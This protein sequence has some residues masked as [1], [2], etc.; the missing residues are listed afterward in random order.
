[1]E[2][3]EQQTAVAEAAAT[4][5]NLFITG[6]GGV[7]KSAMLKHLVSRTLGHKQVEVTAYTGVAALPIGGTTLHSFLGIRPGD[8]RPQDYYWQ[9]RAKKHAKRRIRGAE[10][11]VIDEVSMVDAQMLNVA[12]YV[13]KGLREDPRPFGGVQLIVLGDF[14]QLPPPENVYKLAYESVAW[15]RARIAIHELTTVFR[16]EDAELVANL[17][18]VRLGEVDADCCRYFQQFVRQPAPGDLV[19]ELYALNRDV[20]RRNAEELAKLG[21]PLRTY[22]ADDAGDPW[23]VGF[24]QK[25]CIA[26]TTLDLKTGARVM[27]LKNYPQDGLVNGSLGKVVETKGDAVRVAFKHRGQDFVKELGPDTWTYVARGVT[28]A[29]R[30]QIPL[31][32][33]YAQTIHKAQG[34]TLDAT[35]VDMREIFAEGHGYTGLSRVRTPDGLHLSGFNPLM[36]KTCARTVDLYK[37]IAQKEP[38]F[39]L[40]ETEHNVRLNEDYKHQQQEG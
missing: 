20:D 6:G 3:S 29:T 35:Y 15:R 1:M 7:G 40:A 18:K 10:V 27:L 5:T 17:H 13:M 2:L 39:C 21:A 31:R 32:L 23:A 24:L 26:P 14:L 11:L 36:I 37:I 19:T 38:G 12:D 30:E 8:Y 16:Q 4:G 9:A 28:R 25:N 33:A 34:M 22:H